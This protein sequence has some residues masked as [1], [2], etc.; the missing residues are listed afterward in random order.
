MHTS[1]QTYPSRGYGFSLLNDCKYGYSV[2]E[3]NGMALTLLKSSTYP[4][5][6]AD[7]EIHHFTYAMLPHAGDWR[8]AETP[9][10]AYQLNVR[11]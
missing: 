11:C 9:R 6:E 8:Q 3:N 4:N 7:Q 1:G 5:P 10:N 2:D